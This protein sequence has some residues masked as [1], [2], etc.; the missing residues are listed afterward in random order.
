M[1]YDVVPTLDAL[2]SL[3]INA[4]DWLL[5]AGK[6]K[7][8]WFSTALTVLGGIEIYMPF[9]KGLVGD[10]YGAILAGV[11][12]ITGLLRFATKDAIANK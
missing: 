2:K 12:V 5:K 7:T 8:V 1:A 6:S 3:G 4:K 11:G 10:H 9:I